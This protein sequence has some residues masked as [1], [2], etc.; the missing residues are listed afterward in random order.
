MLEISPVWVICIYVK[1]KK[2]K[3]K[4]QDRATMDKKKENPTTHKTGIHLY[5]QDD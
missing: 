1:K 5:F 3:Q 4:N 2:E